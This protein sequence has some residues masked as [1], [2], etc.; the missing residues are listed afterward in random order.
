MIDACKAACRVTQNEIFQ[1]VNKVINSHKYTS[2]TEMSGHENMKMAEKDISEKLN[3][4]V[5]LLRICVFNEL[6]FL[7]LINALRACLNHFLHEQDTEKVIRYYLRLFDPLPFLALVL[8]LSD[9][10]QIVG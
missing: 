1:A 4:S 7:F 8:G 5:G 6:S 9:Y 2:V 3:I 10:I